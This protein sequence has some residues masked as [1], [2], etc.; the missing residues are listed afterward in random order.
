MVGAVLLVEADDGSDGGEEEAKNQ[1]QWQA[2]NTISE[3]NMNLRS[4]AFNIQNS[5]DFKRSKDDTTLKEPIG[6]NYHPDP[7]MK[8]LESN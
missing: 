6:G 7:D 5:T 3:E 4:G 1:R 2:K 8:R